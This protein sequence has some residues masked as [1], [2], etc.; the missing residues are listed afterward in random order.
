MDQGPEDHGFDPPKAPDGP[1][2]SPPSGQPPPP[3]PPQPPGPP[4]PPPGAVPQPPPP[5]PVPPPP[6]YAPPP[7]GYYAPQP[8]RPGNGQA[9]ASLVLGIC[10]LVFLFFCYIFPPLSLILGILA[11]VFSNKATAAIARGETTQGKDMAK[12]GKITGIIGVVLA[13]LGTIAWIV[14]II[15]IASDPDSFDSDPTPFDGDSFDAIG[16]VAT[17]AKAASQLAF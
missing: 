6:G 14:I 9:V 11:W 5:G 13:I 17:L 1:P 4:P 2:P 8:R 16:A 12:A 3:P 15:L 7:G 10:S